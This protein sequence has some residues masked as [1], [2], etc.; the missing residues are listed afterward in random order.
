M[1]NEGNE[2]RKLAAEQIAEDL[3]KAG[4]EVTVRQ[5]TQDVYLR[6]LQ[7]LNYD[8]YLG[9]A[10]M[11]ESYDLRYLLRSY[12]GNPVGFTNPEVDGALDI[13]RSMK[14]PDSKLAAYKKVRSILQE[15]L[16]YYPLVYKTYGV[17][18]SLDFQGTVQ[19][20]FFHI[21]RDADTWSYKR[22]IPAVDAP[23]QEGEKSE[24]NP[25]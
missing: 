11:G 15:E 21:Y 6:S 9:G 3:G 2:S 20:L 7:S 12:S 19:P 25:A 23:E 4:F 18:T 14:D 17:L 1:I 10:K 8:I 22:T 13:L 16:P 24:E 5:E